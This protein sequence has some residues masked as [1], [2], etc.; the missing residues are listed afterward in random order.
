MMQENRHRE[1]L[2]R[3]VVQKAML[4]ENANGDLVVVVSVELL[5]RVN[6]TAP[7]REHEERVEGTVKL[8]LYGSE[9]SR[10]IFVESLATLGFPID[11]KSLPE[12]DARHENAHQ[13]SREHVY[14]TC[15]HEVPT[16]GK[17]TGETIERWEVQRELTLPRVGENRAVAYQLAALRQSDRFRNSE[18]LRKQEQDHANGRDHEDDL[19]F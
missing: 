18:F 13:W 3:G 17:Y 9:K 10:E 1:G 16:Q 6:E 12:I 7:T 19:P 8:R 2:Y 5:A 14:L 15:K 4:G 11:K